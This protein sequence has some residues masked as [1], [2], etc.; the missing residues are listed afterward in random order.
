MGDEKLMEQLLAYA[1]DRMRHQHIYPFC[2]FV[3]KNGVIISKG[4]NNGLNNW[5]DRT[6][7]GEMVALRKTCQAIKIQGDIDLAGCSIY[8][9]CEPCLACLDTI[10][11]TNIRRI[12]Y[13]VDH[14]DF[15]EYFNDHLYTIDDY[16]TENPGTIETIKHLKHAE[17]LSLFKRAKNKYGW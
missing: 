9:T 2:S 11:W 13:C 4:F 16:T 7:H 1:D 15:P 17:G 12:V 6:T 10:L 8:S 5:G 14:T 3:T